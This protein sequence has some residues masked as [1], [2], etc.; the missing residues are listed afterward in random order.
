MEVGQC[1]SRPT[2]IPSDLPVV[3]CNQGHFP[4]HFHPCQVEP[5]TIWC[6]QKVVLTPKG[7]LAFPTVLNCITCLV[8]TVNFTKL[9]KWKLQ[10]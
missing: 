3:E 1:G 5:V 6:I 8:S 4:G 2:T 9:F 10:V 7:S